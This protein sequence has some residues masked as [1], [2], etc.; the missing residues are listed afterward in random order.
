MNQFVVFVK[1]S[2]LATAFVKIFFKRQIIGWVF[3]FISGFFAFSVNGTKKYIIYSVKYTHSID[4]L[5][6]KFRL[7]RA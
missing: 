5:E 2:K 1:Y 7:I 4:G 6:I 3:H